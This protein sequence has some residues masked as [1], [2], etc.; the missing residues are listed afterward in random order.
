MPLLDTKMNYRDNMCARCR[1]S[2]KKTINYAFKSVPDVGCR[3]KK[4]NYTDKSVPDGGCRIKKL[5]YTDI[6]C[7][8]CRMSDEKIKLYR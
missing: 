6:M 2:N 1:M 4:I 5:N 8:R 7:G 3:I